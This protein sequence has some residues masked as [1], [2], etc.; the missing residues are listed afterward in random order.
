MH[1]IERMAEPEKVAE[2]RGASGTPSP[3]AIGRVR[4]A[5][6]RAESDGIAAEL[7]AATRVA[8]MQGESLGCKADDAFDERLVEA[9]PVGSLVDI[10]SGLL[11]DRLRFLME[12]VHADFGKD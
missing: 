2:I 7:H 11:Q 1:G 12:E 3:V 9:H 6:D 10:R 8:R 4:R 5:R